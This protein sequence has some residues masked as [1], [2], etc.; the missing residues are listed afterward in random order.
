[1]SLPLE[2]INVGG[3]ELGTRVMRSATAE[4]MADAVTGA[5]KPPMRRMYAEL[6]SGHVG[7]IVTGHACIEMQ[8]RAHP[9]M[10]AIDDDALIA[11]W[12]ET[13]QP[14]QALGAKLM[15]QINHCGASADPQVTANPL[16]PSGVATNERVQ[17]G[18]MSDRDI[19]R[20]IGAYA[21]AARRAKSA[22]FDGVQLHGAHGYL[23]TQFLS[24]STNQR[25]DRW[26]GDTVHARFNFLA[27]VIDAVRAQV[28]DTYPVWIK[29]G[30]AGRDDSGL[31]ME[32]GAQIA[33]LCVEH[34][35]DCIEISHAIGEPE[36][37]TQHGEADYWA[38]AQ[39]VRA[40]VG[41]AFPLALVS[42]FKSLQGM[43][44]ALNDG[45]VQLVSLCRPL[46]AQPTLLND[47]ACDHQAAAAC[48]RC[49][50]CWPKEV[51]G[52]VDCHN[53][54]VRRRLGRPI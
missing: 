25:Q 11:A 47:M 50:Q 5:P 49:D 8:G 9:R 40:Q 41:K 51:D 32:Q 28:G 14:A 26:G 46:I 33:A 38:M 54:A 7:L 16:A 15:M 21:Q 30:V 31:T 23:I 2:P 43:A 22:G 3:L 27:H 45:T 18:V 52:F 44:T 29:L 37:D 36:A 12:R 19:E 42:G 17:P 13:I 4:R 20:I 24:A 53:R 34:G 48:V 1:M 10:A 35:I 6:A 39:A